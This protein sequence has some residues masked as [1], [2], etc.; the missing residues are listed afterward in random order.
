MRLLFCTILLTLLVPRWAHAE[1][2]V[3]GLLAFDPPAF[4][5]GLPSSGDSTNS[6]NG[7]RI[8]RRYA[9]TDND[10]RTSQRL[11]IVSLR[12][13]GAVT[14]PGKISTGRPSADQA[15]RAALQAAVSSDRNAVN[16]TSVTNAEVGGRPAWLVTYQMPRPYWQK[17]DAG[18]FPYEVY[19]VKIQTNQV[20]EIKLIADS[21]EH[22]QTLKTCLPR[23]KIT[24][25]NPAAVTGTPG[26][27]R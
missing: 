1:E 12:E 20:V 14:D 17:P 3:P 10:P 19:W 25:P 24:H 5:S 9:A 2:L 13:I 8:L 27:I 11:L 4:L 26:I 15:L 21:V 16:V 7:S 23:F 22:L 6:A 18:L